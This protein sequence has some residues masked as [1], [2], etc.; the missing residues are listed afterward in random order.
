VRGSNDS[1]FDASEGGGAH[2]T[3]TLVLLLPGG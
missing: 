3:T 2:G 1:T